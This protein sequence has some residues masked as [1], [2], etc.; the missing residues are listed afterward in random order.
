MLLVLLPLLVLLLMVV[1]VLLPV[2][3]RPLG[4]APRVAAAAR[5]GVRSSCGCVCVGV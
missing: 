1:L 5:G 2:G 4:V 3:A